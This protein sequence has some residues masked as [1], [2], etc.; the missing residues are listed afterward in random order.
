MSSP[1]KEHKWFIE[2]TSPGTA[3]MFA[4]KDYLVASR[5]PYQQVEIVDTYFFGRMLFLD[6]K[7][8]SAEL[9]EQIY[10]ETLVHPAMLMHEE[11]R[12]V[13]VIGG[14]EGATLR[15]VLRHPTVEQAVMVD[16]DRDVVALCKEY[17]PQWHRGSFDDPRVKLLHQDA[18]KFLEENEAHY[19]VMIIDL[20]EPVEE[21][22]ARRL[23]TW[24]FYSLVKERLNAGGIMALQAGDFSL[25]F[26]EAH[27]AIYNTIKQVMPDLHSYSAFTPSFNSDWSFI[28]AS[29][30]STI[31][32]FEA[33]EIDRR[34]GERHLAL[35]YYDSETHRRM[36]AI[37]RNIRKRR[38]AE[39]TI[40]DD[41]RLLTI[42]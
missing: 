15:E 11:P 16:I 18:R 24:Q 19:D 38:N 12:R 29:K 23:F 42:Y 3:Y 7:V 22:P 5:T 36:F 39:T 25:P 35:D 26:L 34:A 10:H 20:P 31:G 27:S 40:I 30:D 8:Q 2:Q 6:G 33:N 21:G 17:L 13:L 37:P 9:D 14:G 41:D 28:V 1:E 32:A 4:I